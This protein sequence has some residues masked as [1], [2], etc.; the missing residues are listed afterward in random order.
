MGVVFG[1][2]VFVGA[3]GEGLG[4]G[5]D[6]AVHDFPGEDVLAEVPHLLLLQS[7]GAGS[8]DALEH[9]GDCMFGMGMGRG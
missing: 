2:G 5:V 3:S 4:K 7:I 8:D 6:F 1:E 9:A